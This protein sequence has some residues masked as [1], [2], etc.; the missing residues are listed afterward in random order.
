MSEAEDQNRHELNYRTVKLEL[1]DECDGVE[2]IILAEGRRKEGSQRSHYLSQN[3]S[4]HRPVTLGLRPPGGDVTVPQ[5]VTRGRTT[6][7]LC[8]GAKHHKIITHH[9]LILSPLLCF[10]SNLWFCRRTGNV[11]R[12]WSKTPA[13]QAWRLFFVLFSKKKSQHRTEASSLTPVGKTT[14]LDVASLFLLSSL[15]ILVRLISESV[16]RNLH[17]PK[18]PLALHSQ[19]GF[20][21]KLRS[22]FKAHLIL[23]SDATLSLIVC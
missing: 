4:V 13:S 21:K 19:R 16:V 12:A 17:H 22:Y 3:R 10:W 14:S 2:R 23:W 1:Q 8:F 5:P 9:A 18:P 11:W 7:L 6:L 20:L 15:D